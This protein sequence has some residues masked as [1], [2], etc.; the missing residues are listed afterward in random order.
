M[1]EVLIEKII[2]IFSIFLTTTEKNIMVEFKLIY[3]FNINFFDNI[4]SIAKQELG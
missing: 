2:T 4:C 3:S 1:I